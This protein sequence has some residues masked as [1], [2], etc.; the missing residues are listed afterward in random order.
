MYPE[1]LRLLLF[2]LLHETGAQIVFVL[3]TSTDVDLKDEERNFYIYGS[4]TGLLLLALFSDCLFKRRMVFLPIATLTL[5]SILFYLGLIIYSIFGPIENFMAIIFFEGMV[6]TP[7]QFYM[8]FYTPIR[9]ADQYRFSQELTPAGTLIAVILV[10][11]MLFSSGL[12]ICF[13]GLINESDMNPTY[14][15][16][17]PLA[18]LVLSFVVVRMAAYQEFK[19]SKEL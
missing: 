5:I 7:Q 11:T 9:I 2:S 13:Q 16:L 4:V 8:F 18:F 1:T 6:Q 10:N 15:R 14:A 17:I 3:D 12:R 19:D